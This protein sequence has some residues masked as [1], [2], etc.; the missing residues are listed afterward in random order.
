MKVIINYRSNFKYANTFLTIKVVRPRSL[1]Q[2]FKKLGA[3][4][5]DVMVKCRLFPIKSACAALKSQECGGKEKG[6]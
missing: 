4:D 2:L 5:V 3:C 6:G 1:P